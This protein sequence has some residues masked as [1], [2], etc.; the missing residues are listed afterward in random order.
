M[1]VQLPK[2][3]DEVPRASVPEG[4]LVVPCHFVLK[5]KCKDGGSGRLS[6]DRV[7][8]RL[9][10]GGHRSVYGY[11]FWETSAFVASPKSVWSML[12]LAAPRGYKVVTWDIGQADML[13]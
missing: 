3:W 7:K 6:I 5:I 9:V 10:F 4:R 11:D 8:A 2:G 13:R 1:G 12:A